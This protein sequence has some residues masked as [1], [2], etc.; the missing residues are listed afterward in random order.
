MSEK[1]NIPTEV[2]VYTESF[3]EE[4]FGEK[5]EQVQV[6]FRPPFLLIYFTD[7][8]LPTEEIFLKNGKWDTV[9]ETRDILIQSVKDDFLKGLQKYSGHQPKNLYADWNLTKRNGLFIVTMEK[10]NT[11]K[12]FEGPADVDYETLE[13]IILLNSIRTQKKPDQTNLYW[14]NDQT[15]L[16]ERLGVLVDIEKELI[17]N[18]V[19]E[20]LRLAKRPMEYRIVELFNLESVL[21]SSVQ[22]LFVD[23][24]FQQDVSYMVLFL[25]KK[26]S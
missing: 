11:V 6:L 15:L 18:G 7:F 12:G 1:Q 14:L 2:S 3:L 25:D 26:E 20:E 10:E 13:E 23:W 5:P 22:N 9:L 4:H 8:L 19:T 24:D 16:V 21:K 17:K